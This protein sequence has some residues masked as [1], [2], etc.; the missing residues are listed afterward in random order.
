MTRLIRDSLLETNIDYRGSLI[1]ILRFFVLRLDLFATR[2]LKDLLQLIDDSVDNRRL[3]DYSLQ[4]LLTIIDRLQPRINTHRFDIMKILIRCSMKL[5]HEEG[6][7]VKT[8]NLMGKGLNAL[9]SCTAENYVRDSL[10]SLIETS[11]LDVSY[12]DHIQRLL[13]TLDDK[14]TTF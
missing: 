12:R 14:P 11:Q 6:G 13:G 4:L 1:R 7:N 3:R 8:F 2:H 9:Q 5:I 10:Q